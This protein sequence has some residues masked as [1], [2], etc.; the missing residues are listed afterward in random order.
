MGRLRVASILSFQAGNG[1][2]PGKCVENE[3]H[4]Y[5]IRTVVRKP[6][7][8]LRAPRGKGLAW[9]W[10]S[11]L[12]LGRDRPGEGLKTKQTQ[13]YGARFQLR[14]L[15]MKKY[16]FPSLFNRSRIITANQTGQGLVEYLILVSL[17][18][19]SAITIVS[20]VGK[21][22]R[23]QYANI[24]AALRKSERVELTKPASDD[25][26]QRGMDDFSK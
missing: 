1:F 23:E 20:V 18:S 9:L 8:F 24:S 14:E 19:V 17:I 15:I 6:Y 26:G 13:G 11:S 2:S 4:G 10:L 21:N 25:F 3:G 16:Y 5:Q 7:A 22:I 12:P